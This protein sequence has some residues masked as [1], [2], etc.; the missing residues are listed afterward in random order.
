MD[1]LL[2]DSEHVLPNHQIAS[3]GHRHC[4]PFQPKSCTQYIE[5]G[6]LY[7]SR[8]TE[9][10]KSRR[11]VQTVLNDEDTNLAEIE[12]YPTDVFQ[13]VHYPTEYSTMEPKGN[14]YQSTHG[15][16]PIRHS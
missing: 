14:N 16:Q 4:V 10:T 6:I 12:I 3:E 11:I 13:V 15:V 2:V 8:S 1:T 9:R 7:R 5:D